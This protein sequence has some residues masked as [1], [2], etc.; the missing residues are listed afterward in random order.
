MGTLKI[1]PGNFLKLLCWKH[2]IEH[3]DWNTS[4]TEAYETHALKDNCQCAVLF[5]DT[6]AQLFFSE[7]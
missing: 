6:R 3:N 7:Q 2:F 1:E 4:T 5:I